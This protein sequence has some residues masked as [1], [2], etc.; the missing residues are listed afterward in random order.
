MKVIR[1]RHERVEQ[2]VNSIFIPFFYIREESIMTKLMVRFMALVIVAMLGFGTVLAGFSIPYYVYTLDK[3]DAA[4]TEAQGNSKALAF[5][6][7][8][9]D[10]DCGYTKSCSEDVM[11]ALRDYCVIV[12]IP[13]STKGADWKSIPKIVRDA[14]KS[15]QAGKI[16][17]KTNVTDKT[18]KKVITIIP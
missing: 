4:R 11:A 7:S 17:T 3:L 2:D 13:N 18:S 16:I 12:Y 9:K 5:M 10:S 1:Q 6:S 8:D 15:K 14:L